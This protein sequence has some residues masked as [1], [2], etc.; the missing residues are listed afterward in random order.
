MEELAELNACLTRL[1]QNKLLLPISNNKA[2]QLY[3]KHGSGLCSHLI[4]SL[5]LY[6]N[7]TWDA[8]KVREK[9]T[10]A[11]CDCFLW[12][13]ALPS[14]SFSL[15]CEMVSFVNGSGC[16]GEDEAKDRPN[17]NSI[18]ACQSTN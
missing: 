16:G 8:A 4:P 7:V 13:L 15:R 14:R 18:R 9:K 17:L 5:C 6:T 2:D 1:Q 10:L 12:M 3:L 11:L